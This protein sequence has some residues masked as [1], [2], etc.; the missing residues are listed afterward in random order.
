MMEKHRP[1]V[2]QMAIECKE[3]APGGERPDLNLVVVS[4]GYEEWLGAME[5]HASHRSIMLFEP[6]DQGAHAVVP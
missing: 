4:S 5:V 2:V 1:N 3:T 6:V